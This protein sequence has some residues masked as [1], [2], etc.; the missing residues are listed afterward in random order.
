MQIQEREDKDKQD[1]NLYKETVP[2]NFLSL[3][4]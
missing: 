2:E 4:K 1:E 3:W